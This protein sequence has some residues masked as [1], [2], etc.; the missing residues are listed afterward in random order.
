MPYYYGYGFD[1]T[2][3]V[4]V[5][6]CILLSLWASSSVNSF[7]VDFFCK[8]ITPFFCVYFGVYSPAQAELQPLDDLF[9]TDRVKVYLFA[10]SL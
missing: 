2:Y 4:L 1:W 5:L 6:P 9:S 7:F 3:L 10:A 8:S